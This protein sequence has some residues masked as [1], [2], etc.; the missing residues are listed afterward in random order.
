MVFSLIFWPT[1]EN[2]GP[3]PVIRTSPAKPCAGK[4]KGKTVKVRVLED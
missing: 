4:V 2:R 3:S 1:K